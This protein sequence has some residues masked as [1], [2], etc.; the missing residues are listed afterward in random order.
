MSFTDVEQPEPAGAGPHQ[1]PRGVLRPLA[2][3]AAATC[4]TAAW[5]ARG[6][7]YPQRQDG[8]D[9]HGGP[10]AQVDYFVSYTSADRAWAEWIAWLL[11]E[12]GS[13]VVLQAWDM[14]PGH[15]FVHEMQKAT[16]TAK[17]TVAVLS[18]AYL[19]SQ[20]GE[21]GWGVAFASDPRGE[22]GRLVPVRVAEVAPPGLLATRIYIDL[23][24]KNRQAARS[25]LLNGLQ[26][27]PAAIPT[28]EPADLP[29]TPPPCACRERPCRATGPR[30]RASRPTAGSD[31]PVPAGAGA[32]PR[33]QGLGGKGAGG[34]PAGAR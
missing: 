33:G 32:V 28:Q 14:V 8:E 19:T 3:R 24:G 4:W 20:F 17:R 21:A 34:H 5:R 9:A 18:P 25:A 7:Y 11:K 12:S 22:Q 6:A 30:E 1:R 13:S 10:P 16:T 29:A 15:D 31:S 26:G 2:D 23:V 27:Q